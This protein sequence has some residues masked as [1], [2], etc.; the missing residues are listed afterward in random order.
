MALAMHGKGGQLL[1]TS[2]GL[3]SYLVPPGLA[4]IWIDRDPDTFRYRI[5]YIPARLARHAR[6]RVLKISPGWL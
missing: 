3:A 6:E 4:C 1:G 5:W 2:F